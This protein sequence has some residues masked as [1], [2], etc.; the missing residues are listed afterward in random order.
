MN[1][2]LS[3]SALALRMTALPAACT[4]LAVCAVQC[5]TGIPH[6]RNAEGYS[7]AFEF[8]LSEFW[9]L[10]GWVGAAVLA[11]VLILCVT[12][13]RTDFSMTLRRLS[14]PSGRV[15]VIFGAVFGAYFLLYWAVQSALLLG[16]YALYAAGEQLDPMQLFLTTYRYPYFHQLVPLRDV[17]GYGRNVAMALSFG[18]LAGCTVRTSHKV[19]AIL[20]GGL[21]VWF[22]ICYTQTY[23]QPARMKTDLTLTVIG[24]VLTVAA[25]V[26]AERWEKLNEE[27]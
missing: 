8:A 2:N 9:P 14:V 22:G 24:L 5:L 13:L 23:R 17:W 7:Q 18:M 12:P 11:A 10:I 16:L 15:A 1:K 21:L 3:I 6:Y 27:A 4:T 20:G 19:T 26:L 25:A